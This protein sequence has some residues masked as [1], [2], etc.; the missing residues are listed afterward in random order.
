MLLRAASSLTNTKNVNSEYGK[1]ETVPG[2]GRRDKLAPKS[3]IVAPQSQDGI[4]WGSFGNH[5]HDEG[6]R[7]WNRKVSKFENALMRNSQG[8]S[9]AQIERLQRRYKRRLIVWLKD[10]DRDYEIYIKNQTY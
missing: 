2:I 5:Y 6:D 9:E 4:N 3:E 10:R 8:K 1:P 7:A